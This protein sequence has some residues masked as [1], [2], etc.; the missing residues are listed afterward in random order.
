MNTKLLITLTALLLTACSS[1][2]A[3]VEDEEEQ[4]VLF[5]TL[6]VIR[7]GN[8][9]WTNELDIFDN[10]LEL[11]CR[12]VKIREDWVQ[13]AEGILWLFV[14]ETWDCY[15]CP[16]GVDVPNLG[17]RRWLIALPELREMWVP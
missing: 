14:W 16:D 13:V 12:R 2:T 4:C 8:T 5:I 10:Q 11:D 7:S 17:A 15:E 1:P 3:I 6:E 9:Y